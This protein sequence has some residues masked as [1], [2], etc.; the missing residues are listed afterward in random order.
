MTLPLHMSVATVI[1][2]ASA[3]SP[4]LRYVGT[5]AFVAT[6]A[7]LGYAA[8]PILPE[9]YPFL[10]LFLSILLSAAV[11][12]G[13]TGLFATGLS[14]LAAYLLLPPV[15]QF[16]V[17]DARHFVAL[18]LFLGIGATAAVALEALHK[19]LTHSQR[20]L[21][22]LKRSDQGRRLLLREFRHRMRND[23]HS[24][25]GLLLLRARTAPSDAARDGL[26]EAAGHAMA[27][28]RVHTRLAAAEGENMAEAD[29]REFVV[30]LCADIQAARFGE[31]LQTVALLVEAERHVLSAERAVQLGLVLNET[32]T[33]A[34]KY[35]FPEDRAGTVRVRF[36]R[37][38]GD[39]VL[40][41]ADDGIGLPLEGDLAGAPPEL[42]RH[43]SGLGTRLLRALAA[44]LR[45]AFT[46]RPGEGGIG[47]IVELRFPVEAPGLSGR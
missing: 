45:G 34:L 31:G 33:N 19:A 32:V 39:F 29:T 12:D 28:A 4:V 41:V 37:E 10:L 15:G 25:V 35:A 40:V 3:L 26:R 20:A 38:G 24:L 30:G 42:P 22:D 8:G 43:G 9:S 5:A 46:R 36:T 47:T 17:K 11:F 27:L 7:L 1:E 13:G 6:A 23:L 21:T 44:Q 18:A 14:T 16:V 2:R